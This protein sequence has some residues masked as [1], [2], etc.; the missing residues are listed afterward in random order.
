MKFN[1]QNKNVTVSETSLVIG[2]DVGS[3]PHYARVFDYRGM[4]FLKK[5]FKFSI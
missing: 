3:R 1:T 4:E 2:I 5:M